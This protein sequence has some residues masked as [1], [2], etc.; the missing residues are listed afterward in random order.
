MKEL[1]LALS[2]G[3]ARGLAHV[4]VLRAL[5]EKGYRANAI[6][7]C[8]M[9]AILGALIAAGWNSQRIRELAEGLKWRELMESG[10]HGALF[11]SGR[12]GKLL[13][14]NLP[15]RFE[16]L[17]IPL[18]VVAVDC[19]RGESVIFSRG[20]LVPALLA[21]SALPGILTPIQHEGRWLLDGGMLNNLPVDIIRTMTHRPV[22][23]VDTGTPPSRKLDFDQPE[24]LWE[25][26]TSNLPSIKFDKNLGFYTDQ[27]GMTV[28]LF[29]KSFDI[30][31]GMI[32][33]LRLAA[34]P[35][36]LLLKPPLPDDFG[37]EDFQRMEEAIGL[38]YDEAVAALA[39]GTLERE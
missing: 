3:G 7:G 28:E 32:T 18:Q 30:P 1:G 33:R 36:D 17:E 8:S 29:L 39:E 4:G 20:E 23:A 34:N 9:G 13:G 37:I 35:P 2:G 21:S 25:R 5:E 38:G 15:E 31:M 11:G 16:D 22:V 14:Q 10:E 27:R 19:Q 6:A 24:G 26:W 12:I